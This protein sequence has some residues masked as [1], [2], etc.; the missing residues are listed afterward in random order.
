MKKEKSDP[1]NLVAYVRV[2][3]AGQAAS[4]IGLDAQRNAITEA[5]QAQGLTIVEWCED[6]GRS[7]ASMRNRAG[8]RDA[9][10]VIKEGRA[11]GI[12]A[13]KVDRIGRSS[14][15][16]LGLV[17]RAQREGWRLVVLDVGLDSSTPAGELVIAALAMAARFEYRRISERQ[18]EKFAEMRRSSPDRPRGRARVPR[19]VAERIRHDREAGGTLQAIAD[20]LNTGG[21]ATA[22]AG[23]QWHPSTVKS[24]LRTLELEDSAEITHR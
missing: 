10:Q 11:G 17:E 9:L 2:S 6:A 19:D 18:R 24:V 7:G 15:D 14:A 23:T 12:I 1:R 22:R 16:V 4:G 8:L 20:S 21:V 3:T 5:A 13:A